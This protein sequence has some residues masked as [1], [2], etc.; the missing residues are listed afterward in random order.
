MSDQENLPVAPDIYVA[1]DNTKKPG[2]EENK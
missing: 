2:E 1:P